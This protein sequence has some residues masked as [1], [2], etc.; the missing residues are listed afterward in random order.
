MLAISFNKTED[1][2]LVLFFGF[3]FVNKFISLGNSLNASVRLSTSF[4]IFEFSFIKSSLFSTLTLKVLV[5]LFKLSV[6]FFIP[7]HLGFAFILSSPSKTL[8]T[9]LEIEHKVVKKPS[10]MFCL[11]PDNEE[12][13]IIT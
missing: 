12:I 11:F 10:L 6:N 2:T 3:G 8:V 5:K 4:S 7:I 9:N 1:I 13:I